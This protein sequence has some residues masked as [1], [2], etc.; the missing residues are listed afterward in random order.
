MLL[1][2][3]L[4]RRVRQRSGEGPTEAEDALR[5]G[6]LKK[7]REVAARIASLTKRLEQLVGQTE[8]GKE[9]LGKLREGVRRLRDERAEMASR[10]ATAE[11]RAGSCRSDRKRRGHRG[12]RC[13]ARKCAHNDR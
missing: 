4:A 13:G 5:V 7:R 6:L 8:A 12:R 11:A 1:D 10:K 2:S 9:E 3:E